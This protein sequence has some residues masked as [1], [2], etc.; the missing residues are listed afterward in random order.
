MRMGFDWR[1]V[2]VARKRHERVYTE[3]NNPQSISFLRTT[4]Y[5]ACQDCGTIPTD[6]DRAE[7]ALSNF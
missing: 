2:A 1:P 5:A 6:G 4:A 7:M 3:A